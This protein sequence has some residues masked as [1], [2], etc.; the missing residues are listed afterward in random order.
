MARSLSFLGLT[1]RDSGALKRA[2]RLIQQAR[3][4]Y[5]ELGDRLSS[6]EMNIM[7]ARLLLFLGEFADS[8]GLI[9]A[10][11]PV[12]RDLG[13][14][15]RLAY[16]T[17]GLALNQMMMGHYAQARATVNTS[18][19]M[20][21]ALGDWLGITFCIS[22]LGTICVAEDNEGSAEQI[23]KQALVLTKR[24][25]RPEELGGVLSSLT[26]LMLKR[27][28]FERASLHLVDGLQLVA[29][30]HNML[31]ALF[32]IVAAALF[33]KLR[34]NVERANALYSLCKH[35]AVFDKA[36]Y[37]A[38]LYT[39]YFKDCETREAGDAEAGAP[40][41]LLWQAVDDL[42]AHSHFFG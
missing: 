28:E 25:A 11:L 39:P 14:Q 36:T 7:L 22:L 34:G 31:A 30:S 1:A 19:Q 24:N 12:Y 40:P 20:S 33:L 37:F 27:G 42:L 16:F 2:G 9:E 4:I 13:L 18:M 3:Q 17:G 6:A 32:I 23:L 21:Y 38:T 10:T 35:F 41:E 26:Y 8:V 15:Q 5:L 29:K